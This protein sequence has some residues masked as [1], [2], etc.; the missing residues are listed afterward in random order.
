MATVKANTMERQMTRRFEL[1]REQTVET[2]RRLILFSGFA[3]S[4]GAVFA[5]FS[6]AA[7]GIVG[8]YLVIEER[9][10]IAELAACML[11][12][13]RITQP[14]MKLITFWVQSESVAV[15][16]AK[17]QEVV[18][19]PLA[20]TAL[21]GVPPMRGTVEAKGLELREKKTNALLLQ[22]VNFAAPAGSVV[23]FEA[24]NGKSFSALSDVL[25]GY[26]RPDKGRLM[27]DGYLAQDRAG[28]K[29]SGAI[30][31]LEAEPAMFS[32]TLLDNLCAFG[33]EKRVARAK[34]FAAELGLEKRIHR[35]RLGYDTVMNSDSVFER[36]PVNR[37]L[38]ALVR[39]LAVKPRII[40][41][42]EPTA[43]LENRERDA[44]VKC[45]EQMSPRPTLMVSSPDPRFRR[46][47]DQVVTL[48]VQDETDYAD[49]IEKA[50]LNQV[51]TST[52]AEPAA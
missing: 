9:I 45:L 40:L 22:D 19:R 3:Q 26:A 30:A 21:D 32:G 17:L 24:E 41:L 48:T 6:V 37:Q 35:L 8:A 11:L 52:G 38:I 31:K 16:R 27:I 36:D 7:M 50:L 43:V 46:I 12:N 49:W 4:Y 23:L 47:A 14:L 34:H 51:A 39:L 29:G 15:S 18:D 10:G 13:G 42:N 44:L 33:D 2:S 20:E 5:Q 28:Q 1:L 25:T